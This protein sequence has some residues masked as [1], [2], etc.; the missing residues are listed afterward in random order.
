M[1]FQDNF[2]HADLHMG[3]IICQPL[4]QPGEYR[5]AMI[6]AGLIAELEPGDRRNFID[7]FKAIV[8][9]D[10]R[11]VGR[12]IIERSLNFGLCRNPE[13]FELELQSVVSAVHSSG[14]SLGRMG[15]GELLKRVLVSCYE[16]NVKLEPRFVTIVLSIGVVEGLGRRLDPDV[17]I[18]TKAAPYVLKAA[19]TMEK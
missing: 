14:L 3:N 17:D 5:M 12:L 9:N 4:Q 18:M 10:G 6:D 19:L 11:R 16:N 8:L 7:L 13:K 2:I 1:V 15:V